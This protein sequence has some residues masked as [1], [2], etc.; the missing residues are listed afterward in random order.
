MDY[1]KIEGSGATPETADKTLRNEFDGLVK[2]L[3]KA[4]AET[5]VII[6]KTVFRASYALKPET[7]KKE[8]HLTQFRVE[9]PDGWEEVSEKAGKSADDLKAYDSCF[10]VEQY[11]TLTK[12][13]KEALE[14]KRKNPPAGY[15][16]TTSR[17][18]LGFPEF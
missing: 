6:A 2:K 11:L 7:K 13:Q 3:K 15:D 17:S 1:Y 8:T 9:S 10:T 14:G 4:E 18:S 5:E 12:K 16:R